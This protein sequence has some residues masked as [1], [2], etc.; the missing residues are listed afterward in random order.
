MKLIKDIQDVL[1]PYIPVAVTNAIMI[2]GVCIFIGF[3]GRQIYDAV[4]NDSRKSEM[5][6]S[7][8]SELETKIDRLDVKV[9]RIDA[10]IDTFCTVQYV[11]LDYARDVSI[12]VEKSNNIQM[13][14]RQELSKPNPNIPLIER[15]EKSIKEINENLSRIRTDTVERRI[16][17]IPIRDKR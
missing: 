13:E 11:I 16:I 10:E 14:I 15:I 17:A 3:Q 5:I 9:D 1:K 6:L 2:A 7:K 12:A 8:L 4:M